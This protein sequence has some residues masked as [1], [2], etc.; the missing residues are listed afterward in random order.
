MT[1]YRV[2]KTFRNGQSSIDYFEVPKYSDKE[3][4]R[5]VGLH[6]ENWADAAQGGENYG[7]TVHWSRVKKPSKKWLEHK[8]SDMLNTINYYQEKIKVYKNI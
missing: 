4:E 6:L 1:W 8:I 7:W 5:I 3:F 2:Y